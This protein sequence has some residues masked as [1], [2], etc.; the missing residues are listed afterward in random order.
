M[1]EV[2]SEWQRCT[3]NY[4]M[5]NGTTRSVMGVDVKRLLIALVTV[6]LMALCGAC[7]SGGGEAAL[8]SEVQGAWVTDDPQYAERLLKFWPSEYVI[9]TGVES[10]ANVQTI[11]RFERQQSG[12]GFTLTIYSSNRTGN[13]EQMGIIYSPAN[14]GELRLRNQKPVWHRVPEK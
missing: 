6:I 4:E 5:K 8:P 1:M 7:K 13:H 2:T 10:Q 11:D 14:G 3:E 9:L 12:N